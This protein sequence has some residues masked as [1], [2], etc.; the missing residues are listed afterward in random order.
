MVAV[1]LQRGTRVQVIGQVERFDR[2]GRLV[3]QRRSPRGT[4]V[5]SVDDERVIVCFD[6]GTLAVV[7][8]RVLDRV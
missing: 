4:V 7:E 5:T 2:A 1:T 6:D 3:E 8:V